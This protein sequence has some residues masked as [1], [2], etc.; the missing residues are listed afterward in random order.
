[1]RRNWHWQAAKIDEKIG[2]DMTF[3]YQK[4]KKKKKQEKRQINQ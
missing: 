3:F 4:L 1:L 2:F